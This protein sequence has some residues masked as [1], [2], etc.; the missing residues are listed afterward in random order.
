MGKRMVHLE[1]FT[2]CSRIGQDSCGNPDLYGIFNNIGVQNIP[3]V[4]EF[5]SF[6]SVREDEHQEEKRIPY[7]FKIRL[8][9][10]FPDPEQEIVSGSW[11]PIAI[12][13]GS[14][15]ANIRTKMR[16]RF[17]SPGEYRLEF[18]VRQQGET[19]EIKTLGYSSVFRVI[20]N[21]ELVGAETAP[22]TRFLSQNQ[23]VVGT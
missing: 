23:K 6:A 19:M 4:H 12:T 7:E 14:R 20:T 1:L 2:V 16:I 18:S 22:A 15:G 3:A 10:I 21:S 13:P 17:D 5:W 11:Q 9:K 8:L